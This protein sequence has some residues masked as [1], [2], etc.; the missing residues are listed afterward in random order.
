MFSTL[1]LAIVF[2][3]SHIYYRVMYL[4]AVQIQ[5]IPSAS[6][7][8]IALTTLMSIEQKFLRKAVMELHFKNDA[9]WTRLFLK[10]LT[11]AT[12][13]LDTDFSLRVL[14]H[15]QAKSFD[16]VE[17]IIFKYFYLRQ[18]SPR[19]KGKWKTGEKDFLVNLLKFLVNLRGKWLAREEIIFEISARWLGRRFSLEEISSTNYEEQRK[20]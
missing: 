4:C 20:E 2:H 9:W 11:A 12:S 7:T 18:F 14:K 10:G 16:F 6:V 15:K 3:M 5:Q 13:E 1:F 19:P 17:R 8:N